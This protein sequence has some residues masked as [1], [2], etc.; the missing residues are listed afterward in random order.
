MYN[1]ALDN[2]V[3]GGTNEEGLY[4]SDKGY[5]DKNYGVLRKDYDQE[6]FHRDYSSDTNRGIGSARAL[7][8]YSSDSGHTNIR[9]ASYY[10]GY[11]SDSGRG[12]RGHV[13]DYTSDSGGGGHGHMFDYAS[14]NG[15]IRGR[16]RRKSS[17]FELDVPSPDRSQ[18]NRD[19]TDFT[20]PV[21]SQLTLSDY[22]QYSDNQ[23]SYVNNHSKEDSVAD[24]YRDAQSPNDKGRAT[25]PDNIEGHSPRANQDKHEVDKPTNDELSEEEALRMNF[26]SP[27]LYRGNIAD[28]T[29]TERDN[30][31]NP[32]SN[33]TKW[34]QSHLSKSKDSQMSQLNL[35]HHRHKPVSMENS[36]LI[37]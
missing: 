26:M 17:E 35:A 30:S 6:P 32:V 22:L 25:N 36:Y 3:R 20:S 31:R 14:D 1:S 5:L 21:K 9:G 8:D 33:L 10:T 19:E 12:G 13:L 29:L 23:S 15:A 2:N 7:T 11:S 34:Q 18:S 24:Y 16:H 28:T 37:G 4:R 27:P